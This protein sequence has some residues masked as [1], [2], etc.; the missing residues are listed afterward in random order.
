[1]G[2]ITSAAE[3]P[4]SS[5]ESAINRQGNAV[6]NLEDMVE[7][8]ISRLEPATSKLKSG[9]AMTCEAKADDSGTSDFACKIDG[10]RRRIE[11][12]DGRIGHLIDNLEI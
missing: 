10:L 6:G 3:K 8:L 2:P 5:I 7:R 4:A 12:L 9:G 1:M 11:A